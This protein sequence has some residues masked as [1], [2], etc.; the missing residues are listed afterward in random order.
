MDAWPTLLSLGFLFFIS[1]YMFSALGVELFSMLDLSEAPGIDR[2]LNEKANFQDFMTAFITLLRC[3][4]G[5]NWFSI[6]YEC[7]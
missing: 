6:M 1:I 3:A 2:E 4:T 7:S 5:E